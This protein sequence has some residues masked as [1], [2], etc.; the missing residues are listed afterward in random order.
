MSKDGADGCSSYLFPASPLQLL[1]STACLPCSFLG[2][3]R[4]G[5]SWKAPWRLG[6]NVLRLVVTM[7]NLASHPSILSL[8]HIVLDPKIG[9]WVV[10]YLGVIFFGLV[11]TLGC[12]QGLSSCYFHHRQSPPDSNCGFILT[13]EGTLNLTIQLILQL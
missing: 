3:T 6:S 4:P 10:L 9:A 13:L 1:M 12:R 5:G 11:C 8:G 7:V 2:R